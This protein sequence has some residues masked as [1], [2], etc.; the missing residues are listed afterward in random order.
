[1]TCVNVVCVKLVR[2]QAT[3]NL[4]RRFNGSEQLAV[5]EGQWGVGG[6]EVLVQSEGAGDLF[7]SPS[8]PLSPHYLKREK[9]AAQ[10]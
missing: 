4:C 8:P 2:P 10:R 9:E 3:Y 1:M 5:G 7:P 6:L